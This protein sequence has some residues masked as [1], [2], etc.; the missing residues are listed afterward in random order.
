MIVGYGTTKEGLK[1]WVAKNSWGLDW[2]ME[3]YVY[4]RR[5]VCE[6]GIEDA[7]VQVTAYA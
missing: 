4:I 2:G 1:Y 3:G 6:I 7:A 5:G